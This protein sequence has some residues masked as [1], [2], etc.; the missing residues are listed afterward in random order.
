MNTKQENV[1]CETQHIYPPPRPGICTSLQVNRTIL[2]DGR[3]DAYKSSTR[4]LVVSG[5]RWQ[6]HSWVLFVRDQYQQHCLPVTEQTS[7][8]QIPPHRNP[9]LMPYVGRLMWGPGLVGRTL[10]GLQYW[11]GASFQK[12]PTGF[13]LTAAERRLRA[14]GGGVV[15]GWFE[16]KVKQACIGIMEL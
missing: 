8:G 11:I 15:W 14:K 5:G 12:I 13:C 6:G 1:Q 4:L 7:S 10:S 9:Y 2:S 16:W 3:T